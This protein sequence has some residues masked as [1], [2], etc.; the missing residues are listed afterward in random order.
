MPSTFDRA[1]TVTRRSLVLALVPAVATWLDL[2]K[3]RTALAT[4][5]G[6]ITFPFPTGLPTLWTY[7]SLPGAGGTIPLIG[8]RGALPVAL[9]LFLAGLAFAAALEAGFL[10]ALSNRIDSRPGGFVDGVRRFGVRMFG[11]TLVRIG[12][13]LLAVPLLVVPPLALAVAVVLSYLVY[14]LPFVVVV[15][16]TG[17]FDAL[18]TTAGLATDGGAYA[19]FGLVHLVVGAAGSLVLSATVSGTGLAGPVLG[20]ALVAVPA[21]FVA[22]FGLLTVRRLLG[23]EPNINPA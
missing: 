12:V 10:A 14:G 3:V 15:A 8:A 21:V 11:V 18:S 5:G 16:D 22:A 6:G 23:T 17:V 2:S 7:V 9:V 13:V 1:S 20:T 4:D 19:T